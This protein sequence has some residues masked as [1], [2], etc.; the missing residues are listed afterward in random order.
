MGASHDPPRTAGTWELSAAESGQALTGAAIRHAPA[1]QE[2]WLCLF[3]TGHPA[4][5]GPE[6][7]CGACDRL[8]RLGQFI[9]RG[10]GGPPGNVRLPWLRL[11]RLTAPLLIMTMCRP[12]LGAVARTTFDRSGLRP[13]TRCARGPAT[14]DAV[15]FLKAHFALHPSTW[16]GR[17]A[18]E[19][20]LGA[21]ETR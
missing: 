14:P 1:S 16:H 3:L 10:S 11:G 7:A 4:R 20:Q 19:P 9:G 2:L 21:V 15:L 5:N 18:R 12:R 17:P 13:G 8:R 6:R